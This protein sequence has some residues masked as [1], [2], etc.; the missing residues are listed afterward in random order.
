MDHDYVPTQIVNQDSSN[1]LKK[2]D[3]KG[4]WCCVPGCESRQ[5]QI[6]DRLKVSTGISFFDFPQDKNETKRWCNLIRRQPGRDGFNLTK[7]TKVCMVHFQS[8]C[9]KKAPGSKRRNR[10]PGSEPVLFSWNNFTLDIKQRKDPAKRLLPTNVLPVVAA[11]GSSEDLS[12]SLLDIEVDIS[13]E[14]DDNHDI[15]QDQMEKHDSHDILQRQIEELK[16]ELAEK[17]QIIKELQSK[18][19]EKEELSIID[20]ITSTDDKCKHYTGFPTISRLKSVFE[21]LDAG[22]NGENVIA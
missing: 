10:V 20:Q 19:A 1:V 4:K 14:A 18:L 8:D 9:I 22:D 11:E 6:V 13:A 12:L 7:Y 3:S 15:L 17:D 5:Y 21:F 2:R 16:L